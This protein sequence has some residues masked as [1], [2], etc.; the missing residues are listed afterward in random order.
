MQRTVQSPLIA[1]IPTQEGADTAA[2]AN[3][4][5]WEQWDV[6]RSL[7]D[8]H[9]SST[10]EKNLEHMYRHYGFHFPDPQCLKDPQG[11]LRYLGAKLRYGRVALYTAGGDEGAKRFRSLHAVQRHMVD[12]G[13]CQLCYDGNEDE[14]DDFYEYPCAPSL[15]LLSAAPRTALSCWDSHLARTVGVCAVLWQLPLPAM[16]VACGHCGA[17]RGACGS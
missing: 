15:T 5:D 6:R 4:A 14:Y 7:F 8:N 10:F 3:A 9:M 16:P 12:S 2:P 1:H 13:R 17:S 11:L